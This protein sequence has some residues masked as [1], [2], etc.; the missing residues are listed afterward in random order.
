MMAGT[1]INIHIHR[2]FALTVLAAGL[3]ALGGCSHEPGGHAHDDADGHAE[4]EGSGGGH[5]DG[6]SLVYTHYTD[7]SE[8]FVEFPPL[9]A[10]Q[11]SRF[12]AHVTRLADYRPVT[13]G[14]MDVILSREGKT[15]ARFRVEAP[16]RPGIFTPVVTP[17]EA[18]EYELELAV[19][20]PQLETVHQLGRIRV[21]GRDEHAKVEQKAPEGEI[22]FLKEQQWES[23]FAAE[24]V[25]TRRLK[26]SLY[27]TASLRAPADRSAVVRAP[28]EGHFAAA[29]QAFPVVG[30]T[31]AQGEQL[32]L[33]R[34]RLGG[35]VDLG[36][37]RQAAE[38]AAARSRLARHNLERL[39]G[40]L[41]DGAIPGYRVHEAE[42]ELQ[43]AVAEHQAARARLAQYQGRGDQAA[44]VPVIAPVA[45]RV[46]AVNV[47]PGEFVSADQGLFQIAAGDRRW[48]EARIA[49]ADAGRL[50]KP[51][52][53]WFESDGRRQ[54]I[55]VGENARLVTAGGVI[56]PVSRTVPVIFEFDAEDDTP[57]LNRGFDARIYTGETV[58]ALAVPY[59][60]LID[61]GGQAVVFVQ[62]AGETFARRPVQLDLRGTEYVAVTRG[63]AAGERVVSR[64]AYLV[65]LA[66]A[67]T[68]ETGHGHAH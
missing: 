49:E 55:T 68:A 8:L 30:E 46:V 14:R 7:A 10:G 25:Q 2:R 18:G 60:A 31:V 65:R 41:A 33:L 42:T 20:S 66:A 19:E 26:A 24:P 17:R 3:L 13:E 9:V 35:G 16:S 28:S 4:H 57:L 48:L 27:A 51:A 61:D 36:S 37:L 50:H 12:A 63:L 11:G 23:E 62:T 43:V 59:S 22:S 1:L 29:G 38:K 58:E 54:E 32:G 15:A 44:G 34:P 52:G 53:A 64:D 6:E 47:A 5:G 45:G 56:D 67:G 40:L 21:H 39:R